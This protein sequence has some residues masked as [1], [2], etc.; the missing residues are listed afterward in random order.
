MQEFEQ[1]HEM[2]LK[3]I[4]QLV[5]TGLQS[6]NKKPAC[7]SLCYYCCTYPV[8][9]GILEL[10][11]IVGKINQ[12]PKDKQKIIQQTID[13]AYES[14]DVSQKELVEATK[15]GKVQNYRA[16]CPFLYN[17]NCIIYDLRPTNCRTHFSSNVTLCQNGKADMSFLATPKISMLVNM[18]SLATTEQKPK[19]GFLHNS[20]IYNVTKDLFEID[21][22]N[23]YEED[24]DNEEVLKIAS[25]AMKDNQ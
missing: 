10:K 3:T 13:I 8:P 15:L 11:Y 2:L 18:S 14:L 1:T 5:D 7:K 24:I 16:I 12:M 4:D 20:F 25:L 17:Q 22:S 6:S 21:M 19:K 9:V 23:I